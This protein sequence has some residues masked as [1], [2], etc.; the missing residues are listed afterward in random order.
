[1]GT[2]S[3]QFYA[4][5]TKKRQQKEITDLTIFCPDCRKR[6]PKNECPQKNIH[7]FHICAKK[8]TILSLASWIE[9][10]VSRR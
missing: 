9:N 1:M 3:Y 8:H 2:L 5:T 4:S 6:N 7:I 10:I